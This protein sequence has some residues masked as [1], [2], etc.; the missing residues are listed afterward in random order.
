M[1][2]LMYICVLFVTLALLCGCDGDSGSA[3]VFGGAIGGTVGS[4]GGGGTGGA[5]PIVTAS[6]GGT[7]AVGH[8]GTPEPSSLLLMASGLFGCAAFYFRKFRK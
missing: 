8:V 3:G 7:G 5:A 6:S 2:K 4:I 1:K